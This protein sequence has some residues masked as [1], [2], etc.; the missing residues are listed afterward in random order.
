[1]LLQLTMIQPA[2]VEMSLLNMQARC[3]L[4]AAAWRFFPS[5]DGGDSAQNTEAQAAAANR[6]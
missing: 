1:M 2:L 3:S 4:S 5:Y 6:S